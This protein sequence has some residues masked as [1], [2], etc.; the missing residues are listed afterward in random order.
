M[1]G[2]E[3]PGAGRQASHGPGRRALRCKRSDQHM[4]SARFLLLT[5]KRGP[6][7]KSHALNCSSVCGLSTRWRPMVHESNDKNAP[8]SNNIKKKEEARERTTINDQTDQTHDVS[9]LFSSPRRLRVSAWAADFKARVDHRQWITP[10]SNRYCI[11][12]CARIDCIERKKGAPAKKCVVACGLQ[13]PLAIW[14][15]RNVRPT[16]SDPSC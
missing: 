15:R 7:I 10:Q 14:K 13:R 2:A 12:R 5:T 4:H 1:N 9:R 11:V 3:R 16:R 6:K 8:A